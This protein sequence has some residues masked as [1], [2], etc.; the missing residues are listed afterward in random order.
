MSAQQIKKAIRH[1]KRAIALD[2]KRSHSYV[3]LGYGQLMRG[4][5]DLARQAYRE[6]LALDPEIFEKKTGI[7]LTYSD[8]IVFDS[9][10]NYDMARLFARL[11]SKES[12]LQFLSNRFAAGFFDQKRFAEESA[13]DRLRQSQDFIDLVELYGVS[14]GK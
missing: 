4:R 7:C 13:F 11:G 6:A 12:H 1:F 3:N 2:P 10:L 14:L 8:P 9:E 5:F